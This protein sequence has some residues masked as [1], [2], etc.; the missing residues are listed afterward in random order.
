MLYSS[1]MLLLMIF[2]NLHIANVMASSIKNSNDDVPSELSVISA[3]SDNHNDSEKKFNNKALTSS[4]KQ[5]MIAGKSVVESM[6]KNINP[7]DKYTPF[8]KDI[9]RY[10]Q[11]TIARTYKNATPHS[12]D[13]NK[14]V[15]YY[16]I[17]FSMPDTMIKSYML[18]AI[19]N[20]GILVVRGV[21]RGMAL[22]QFFQQYL[23]PLVRYKGDHAKIEINPNLFE[24]YQ[25]QM[26]PTILITKDSDK[27]TPCEQTIITSTASKVPYSSC[28]PIDSLSYWKISGNVTT[29][30][31]LNMLKDAGAP[32]DLF[33][34]RMKKLSRA[35][36]VPQK[37]E[38]GIQG[39]WQKIRLP[40]DDAT[41]SRYLDK[42]GLEQANDGLITK[43]NDNAKT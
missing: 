10:N 37:E 42:Y 41:I 5:G 38:K 16:F 27:N 21:P 3:L 12:V 40:T 36:L 14:A 6:L 29:T 30:W 35:S 1:L 26:V 2:L 11:E 8:L 43:K 28:K 9:I 20:G 13:Q 18:D 32:A 24:M 31:A 15:L 22:S 39:D 33:T 4:Q 23:M 19:W 7:D 25:I 34:Q 17:S